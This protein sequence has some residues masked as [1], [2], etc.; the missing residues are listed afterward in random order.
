L[1]ILFVYD[2]LYPHTIGGFERFYRDVTERL[3]RSH[4]VTYLTRVQWD[5]DQSPDAPPGV[6][7]VAL[8]C[9]RDLYTASGRRRVLPPLRF[10]LGV[11]THLLRNRGKYDI[12]QTCSFPYFPMISCAGVRALGGPPIVTDWIEI[13][14]DQYWRRYLGP[15]GGR[16]GAAVQ[17]LCIGLTRNAFTLSEL[18]ANALR[19]H[20]YRNHITVLKGLSTTTLEAA[21]DAPREPVFVFA[22]RHIPEKHAD[23]IPGAIAIARQTIPELRAKIFGDGPERHKILAEIAR[24]H[25]GDVIECPGFMPWAQLDASM[26]TAIGLILPSEREGYG[27]VVIEAIARGT[28]AIVVRGPDNAAT[29]LIVENVNGFVA[30]S[31]DASVLAE[32]MVKLYMAGPE[33]RARTL[34]WYREHAS[35]LGIDAT[36]EQID[37]VYRNI[38]NSRK[39]A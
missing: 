14:S 28:P 7:L 33:L 32:H 3:A 19:A 36:I 31:V 12:V 37:E 30:P 22:G 10:G 38:G 17:N 16:I 39:A 1:R 5:R 18:A 6:K 20:G 9:G 29:D 25:L 8:D 35:Q 4:E 15:L 13:W 23:K 34:Q 24:L 27:S 21:S 2:C 26:R 11:F